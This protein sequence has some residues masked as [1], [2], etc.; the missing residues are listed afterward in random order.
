MW[1]FV[2]RSIKTTLCVKFIAMPTITPRGGASIKGRTLQRQERLSTG[3][4]SNYLPF[5]FVWSTAINPLAVLFFV[6]D[7]RVFLL[8]KFKRNHCDVSNIQQ[9]YLLT[10]NKLQ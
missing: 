6:R 5:L 1:C 4:I 8:K 10:N 3:E 7:Y 2:R 9:K